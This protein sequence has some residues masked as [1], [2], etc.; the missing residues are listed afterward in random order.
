MPADVDE[1]PLR[2]EHPRSLAK[3]LSKEKA[4]AAQAILAREA[5]H[6]P[7]FVLAADTVVCVGRRILP[8]AESE[9]EALACLQLLSGRAHRVYT[10]VA[11][12]TPT[13]KFRQRLVETRLRFKRLT[14]AEMDSYL[15]S[16]EWSGKAGGYAIQGIAGTFVVKLAGSYSNVVGLPL[17]ETTALLAGDG[18]QIH[19]RWVA[20]A[21]A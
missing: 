21:G 13:G 18:F 14:R 3:R 17:Y 8:K 19:P 11:L 20:G 10:G 16:G 12:I 9:D 15:A 1:T 4:E 5:G 7:A 2:A 6:Q